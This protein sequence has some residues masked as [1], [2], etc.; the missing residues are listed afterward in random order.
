MRAR[1]LWYGLSLGSV[2]L[3][4]AIGLAI[5][6]GVMGIIQHGAWR[7]GDAR[8]LYDILV[9]DVVRT[10]FPHLFDWSLA[11]ALPLR[12]FVT[13]AWAS[14]WNAASSASFTVAARNA[15]CHRGISLILQQTVRT[16]SAP[17]T[18]KSG[19]PSWMSGAFEIGGLAIPGTLWIIVFAPCLFA[20]L[21]FLLKKTPMGLQMRAVTQ[22]GAWPP[23]WASAPPWVDAL[24]FAL[25][26]A[27]AGIA[28][29]GAFADRQRLAEP[30]AGLHHRQLHGR[31]LRRRRQSLGTLVGAFSLGILNKFLEPYAGAVL[32]R[33]SC[34]C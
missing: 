34:S 18:A 31:G 2:L 15:A 29:C 9:Q 4:A 20:A 27:L 17:P 8:R 25:A 3:L 33:S 24:T 19:N 13:G 22:T 16:I 14:H 32:A 21:L 26:P 23:P 10:S 7:D 1:T 11:I 30:R 6:F 28:G 5:T 12:L